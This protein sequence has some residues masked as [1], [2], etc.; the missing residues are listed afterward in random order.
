MIILSVEKDGDGYIGH[1]RKGTEYYNF[2]T[3]GKS[4]LSR[5]IK[6][7]F[8]DDE[9]FRNVIW[10]FNN[11]NFLKHPLSCSELN[12]KNIER[13]YKRIQE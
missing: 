13:A 3:D 1:A 10:K 12:I 9:H 11:A 4:V 6:I 8:D 5:K 2:S 7:K